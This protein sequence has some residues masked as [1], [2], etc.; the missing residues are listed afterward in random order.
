ML[1]DVGSVCNVF[2]YRRVVGGGFQA[3]V[4]AAGRQ[5]QALRLARA[6]TGASPFEW[7]TVPTSELAG[8]CE[9]IEDEAR[10]IRRAMEKR[11]R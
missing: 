10:L 8:W 11:K 5:L 9:I 3:V 1:H 4:G 7:L 2:R 6:E